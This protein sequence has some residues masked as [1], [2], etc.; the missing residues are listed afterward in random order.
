M[1][2]VLLA[3]KGTAVRAEGG[4]GTEHKR[5]RLG[6]RH[7]GGAMTTI[8]ATCPSCGEVA[9]TPPDIDL[10]VDP[11][12]TDA[13]FYAFVCPSCEGDVRK[14][15]D[16]RVVRLLISGGVE[17]REMVV[18]P[19]RRRLSERF[20]WPRLT[21]DDLLDFHALLQSDCWFDRLVGDDRPESVH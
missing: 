7:W 8:K 10:R 3:F 6:N 4:A 14:P 1:S 17:A 2:L 5:G 18:E 9:L 11:R 16:D 21:H 12:D 20:D 15:A 19:P 13:S